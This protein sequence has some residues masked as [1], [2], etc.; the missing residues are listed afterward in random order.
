MSSR[1][2]DRTIAFVLLGLVAAVFLVLA[3]D[4][5]T[6]PFG[7]SDE[8]IN[9]AVWATNSR[10]LRELGLFE[11]ALGGRRADGTGTP[12]IHRSSS[13]RR[14]WPRSPPASTPSRREPLRGWGPWPRSRC[15]TCC[16]AARLG[17]L[18]AAAGAAT[19][20]LTPMFVVYGPMLDTPVT[21]LPFGIAVLIMWQR[22]V[23]PDDDG[24]PPWWAAAGLSALACFAGWQ[25][26]LLVGTCAA[27]VAVVRRAEG[28]TALRRAGAY[29]LG[30]IV[31]VSASVA[32]IWWAYGDLAPLTEKFSRRAGSA[33]VSY[34]DVVAFQVPWLVQLLGL[35]LVGLAACVVAAVRD[36]GLRPLATM[37]LFVTF[38][39]AVVFKEAAA[40]HQFWL[41]WVL[42]PTAIGAGYAAR[43]IVRK[44]RSE[45]SAPA[46]PWVAVTGLLVLVGAVNL[47]PTTLAE[48]QIV[49]GQAAGSLVEALGITGAQQAG[50]PVRYI[51]QDRRPEDYVGYIL[52]TG[53]ER[54]PDATALTELARQAPQTPVL[55]LTTCDDPPDDWC[56]TVIGEVAADGPVVRSA[57]ELAE[58][59]GN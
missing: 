13:S 28:I 6:G 7:D 8:G 22:D 37:S 34:L 2:A 11:S 36:D 10:A 12:T 51:G 30:G 43:A 38:A 17:P 1:A 27:T 59:F 56:E 46:G 45:T 15:C 40:G 57:A 18:P 21:S 24:P 44:V 23:R 58:R 49:E 42:V 35:A 32:S 41:Y 47:V 31:G 29:A 16:C 5:I 48:E 54:V 50:A 53:V 39:Y 25:A 33:V 9:A 3:A 14:R 20:C 52:R 19:A 55:V 26:T 4:R